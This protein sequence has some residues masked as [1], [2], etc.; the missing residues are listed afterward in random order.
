MLKTQKAQLDALAAGSKRFDLDDSNLS[1]AK[2]VLAEVKKRLDVAPAH[3]RGRHHLRGAPPKQHANS[4][5]DIGKEIRE[6]FASGE[7]AQ[8]DP[9][10]GDEGRDQ[11]GAIASRPGRRSPSPSG[12][13]GPT[14]P[15]SRRSSTPA[16]RLISRSASFRNWRQG[17]LPSFALLELE[18]DLGRLGRG[19]AALDLHELR[20]VRNHARR[21]PNRLVRPS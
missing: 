21:C 7:E 17:R 3:D 18:A 5:R 9:D 8:P 1:K 14:P 20:E 15:R 16:A 13:A 19:R 4:D 10:R 6:Y 12:P 11:G 2:E